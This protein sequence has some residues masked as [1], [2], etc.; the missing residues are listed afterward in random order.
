ME[1]ERLRTFPREKNR[2]EGWNAWATLAIP[3]SDG[4]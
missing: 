1:F 3:L 2:P 4:K